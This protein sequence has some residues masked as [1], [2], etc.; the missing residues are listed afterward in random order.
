V[1]RTAVV[2]ID[3]INPYGQADAD[4]LVDWVRAVLPQVGGLIERGRS[5]QT[6]R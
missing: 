6:P 4:K 1:S 3:M 2:V 5:A